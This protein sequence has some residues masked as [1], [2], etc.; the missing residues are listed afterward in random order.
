VTE[1][2]EP[3]FVPHAPIEKPL[4]KEPENVDQEAAILPIPEP[5][6][7]SAWVGALL[8]AATGISGMYAILRRRRADGEE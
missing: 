8:L 7:A 2:T 6:V 1:I 3:V 4:N 5:S